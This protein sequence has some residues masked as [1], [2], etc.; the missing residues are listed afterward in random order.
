MSSYVVMQSGPAPEE[1]V[2]IRD[3]FAPF[4]FLLPV[5]WLAWHRL[6]I[7]TALALAAAVVLAAMATF[8][9]LD[10]IVPFLSTLVSI[11]VGLEGN[12]LRIAALERRGWHQAGLIE[13]ENLEEAELRFFSNRASRQVSEGRRPP[14]SVRDAQPARQP[15]REGPILG[16]LDYPGRD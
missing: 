3:R 10:N 4:A 12:Q 15:S 8:P 2:F 7:E 16:L 14:P 11:F 6:W 5:I 9:A 1:A 13:A